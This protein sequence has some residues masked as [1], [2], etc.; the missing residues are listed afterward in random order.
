MLHM[1]TF[2]DDSSIVLL[3]GQARKAEGT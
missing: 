2:I 1:T 3:L